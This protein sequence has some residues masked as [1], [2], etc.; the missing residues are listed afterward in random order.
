MTDV[1]FKQQVLQD[2]AVLKSDMYKLVGNGQPGRIKLLEDRVFYVILAIIGLA[3]SSGAPAAL[4]LL[5]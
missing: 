2:L 1:E 4:A 3:L 5:R